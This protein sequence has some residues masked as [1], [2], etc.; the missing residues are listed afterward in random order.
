MVNLVS[1]TAYY[2]FVALTI[3]TAGSALAR[4]GMRRFHG[5]SYNEIVKFNP[6]AAF[7]VSYGRLFPRLFKSALISAGLLLIL[8]VLR[9]VT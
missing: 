1:G 3:L 6:P 7:F 9:A 2:I 5:Q 8:V 4:P